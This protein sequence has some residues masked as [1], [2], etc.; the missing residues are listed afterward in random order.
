M[1]GFVEGKIKESALLNGRANNITNLGT[2]ELPILSIKNNVVY[3][4]DINRVR[5]RPEFISLA[6]ESTKPIIFRIRL[7]PT[8]AGTPAFADVNANT[9][10]S[11]SDVAANA[12]TSGSEGKE[13]YTTVL[14]KADSKTIAFHDLNKQLNPGDII[15]VTAEATSGINQE[16]TVSLT[17]DELF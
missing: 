13:I 16:V 2:T 3:Q 15:T 8:L 14:G 10:V 5:I 4:S 17:W 11:S 6:T 12:L 1:A 7:N 9:S